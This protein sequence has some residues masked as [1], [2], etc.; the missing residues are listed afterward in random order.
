VFE[1]LVTATSNVMGCPCLLRTD[2]G[3]P[4]RTDDRVLF[5]SEQEVHLEQ[6]KLEVLRK[7]DEIRAQ[8]RFTIAMAYVLAQASPKAVSR[9]ALPLAQTFLPPTPQV[10]PQWGTK[11]NVTFRDVSGI[12]KKAR[13]A[14]V[15]LSRDGD[16]WDRTASQLFGVPM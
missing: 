3:F 1:D 7:E 9:D 8:M 10:T 12:Q 16:N 15:D 2:T 13:S 14:W 4:I 6:M 5:A 11:I